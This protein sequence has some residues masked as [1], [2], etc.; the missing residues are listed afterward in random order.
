M[1]T[2]A[3][4]AEPRGSG[5]DTVNLHQH[6]DLL[7]R[8][9]RSDALRR[10]IRQ[11]VRPGDRV[12]D[13]GCGTGLL[14][15]W[16]ALAGAAEVVG[17][18]ID[19]VILAEETARDNGCGAAFRARQMSLDSYCRDAPD[20]RFDVVLGLLYFNDP[21]RDEAQS[22]LVA[23]LQEACLKPGGTLIPDRVEYRMQLWDW[24]SQ[25]ISQRRA[26][27]MGRVREAESQL[28]I[29]LSAFRSRL[30]STTDPR[31]F[32]TRRE[33]GELEIDS[34]RPL[35][36]CESAMAVDYTAGDVSY[37]ET[38]TI[39]A[40]D[41]GTAR[42]LVWRQDLL[43]SGALVFRNDSVSWIEEPIELTPRERVEFQLDQRWR[44][45]NVV[46]LRRGA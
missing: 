33:T 3:R 32:P 24:P 9:D 7:G 15:V 46:A 26:R 41:A 14:S 35:T 18:D 17:V 43:L 10:L 16:A 27:L 21:R 29:D 5:R 1:S 6:L 25:D 20:G 39:E 40:V 44:S 8:S 22:R 37:P 12:L 30:L 45:S 2:A 28:G 31:S 38:L 19:E 13:A 11:I 34:A 4:L 42:T 23:S 36:A